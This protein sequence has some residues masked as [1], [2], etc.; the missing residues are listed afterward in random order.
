MSKIVVS[1]TLSSQ[2]GVAATASKT[3]AVRLIA[4]FHI[5]E[6]RATRPPVKRIVRYPLPQIVDGCLQT[7]PASHSSKWRQSA[8]GLPRRLSTGLQG[9]ELS[10]FQSASDVFNGRPKVRGYSAAASAVYKSGSRSALRA[11]TA[12]ITSTCRLSP[13]NVR[14]QTLGYRHQPPSVGR[15]PIGRGRLV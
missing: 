7:R 13:V 1:L 2:P 3:N 5:S 4:A 8:A 12:P 11:S 6:R 10:V 15:R 9:L 14:R